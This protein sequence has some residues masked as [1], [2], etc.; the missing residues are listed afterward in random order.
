MAIWILALVPP[1]PLM[2]AGSSAGSAISTRPA[3]PS[4][5]V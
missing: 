2:D 5:Y 3:R 1:T 4:M